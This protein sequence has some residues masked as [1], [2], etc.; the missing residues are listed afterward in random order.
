MSEKYKD[1]CKYFNYFEHL[2]I[3]FSTVTGWLF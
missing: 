2:L 1:T 3:L